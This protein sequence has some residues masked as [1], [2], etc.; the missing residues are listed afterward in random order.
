MREKDLASPVAKSFQTVNLT[1]WLEEE[2]LER[3]I[4]FTKNLAEKNLN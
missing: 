2:S 4:K 3:E 1:G